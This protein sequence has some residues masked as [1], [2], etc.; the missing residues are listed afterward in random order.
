MEENNFEVALVKEACQLCGATHDGPIVM[1]NRLTEH[2]AKKVK[3]MHGKCIGYS[4]KPCEDCQEIMD[5]S[6][7]LIGVVEAKT[8]SMD[9]PY[10]SGNKWG[11]SEDFIKRAFDPEMATQFLKK[12]AGFISVEAAHQMGFPQCNL[13]A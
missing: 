9:N 5:Q 12:R 11:V 6:I 1:N 13:D 10:R 4:D 3:E 2:H 8:E 7:L